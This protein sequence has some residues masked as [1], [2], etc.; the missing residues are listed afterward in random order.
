MSSFYF[1]LKQTAKTPNTCF[2]DILNGLKNCS[3]HWCRVVSWSSGSDHPPQHLYAIRTN[4]ACC[5][6]GLLTHLLAVNNYF[7]RSLADN[8]MQLS[9]IKDALTTQK[10]A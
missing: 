9:K 4:I 7:G 6:N 1:N 8:N 2:Q 5:I 10:S 3:T